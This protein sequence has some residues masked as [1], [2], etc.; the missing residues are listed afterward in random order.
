MAYSPTY[1]RSKDSGTSATGTGDLNPESGYSLDLRNLDPEERRTAKI[2]DAGGEAQQNRVE[3]SLKAARSAAKFRKKREYDQPYT[4]RSGQLSGIVE[5]DD[6]PY[7]GA[8][9][10]AD[11]PKAQFGKF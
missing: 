5:G 9:N 2:A 6:F 8:T 3:K 7:A 11:K 10:Y 1:D 4:D